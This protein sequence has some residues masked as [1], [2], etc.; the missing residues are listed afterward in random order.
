[1]NSETNTE[2]VRLRK[3]NAELKQWLDERYKALCEADDEVARIQRQL[4]R[5]SDCLGS[6]N[7]LAVKYAPERNGASLEEVMEKLL[8][9]LA[10]APNKKPEREYFKEELW[11]LIRG[12]YGNMQVMDTLAVLE[13]VKLE[14]FHNTPPST[15]NNEIKVL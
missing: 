8:A 11:Q 12:R 13:W 1:M 9:R 14:L 3:E 7:R 10:T 6:I 4:D 2:V 15:P 5:Y